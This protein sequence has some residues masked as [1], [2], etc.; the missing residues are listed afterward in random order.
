VNGW[1][2]IPRPGT[3]H[4]QNSEVHRLSGVLFQEIVAHPVPTDLEAVKLLAASPGVLDLLLW[5]FDRCFKARG[6]ESIPVF[7]Q[8]GLVQQLGGVEYSRPRCFRVMLEQWLRVIHALWPDCPARIGP[9]G[10][11]IN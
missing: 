3:S 1:V 4:F 8:M 2:R 7:G 6:N 11:S 5:L 9:D 10:N